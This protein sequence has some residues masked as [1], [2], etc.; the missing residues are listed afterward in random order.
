MQP[1]GSPGYRPTRGPGRHRG[2]RP[3]W[4]PAPAQPGDHGQRRARGRA[5]RAGHRAAGQHPDPDGHPD[6]RGPGTRGL[7]IDALLG[8][9]LHGDPRGRA[10]EL[11]GWADAQP[12]PVLS[13]DGPSGLDLDTGQQA[14]PGVRADATMTVALPRPGLAAAQGTGR[15][16]L[17]D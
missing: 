11:I 13:L 9:G 8:Y 17:A 10:A 5:A 3:G 1:R 14:K 12:A 2:R 7:V 15:L 4:R 6:P 16:D